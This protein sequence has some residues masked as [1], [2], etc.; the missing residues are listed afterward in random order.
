MTE[1][2]RH[3]EVD[4]PV[5]FPWPPPEDGPILG[6][7]G[8]TWKRASLEPAAFFSRMPRAGGMGAALIYYLAIGMLVA[9]ATFFW[10]SLGGA[11]FQPA[12]FE[13]LGPGAG[14][15]PLVSFLLSPVFL[16]L[17]LALAGGVTHVMLLIVGGATHG[18]AT[19]LRVFCYAYSPQILG[20]IPLAGTVVGTI[21]M[22]VVAIIGLRTAHETDT[23]RPVLAVLLP[24][25]L[26][27]TLVV[28]GLIMVIAAG[29]AL[30][31]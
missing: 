4:A 29:A 28:F 22:L 1:I 30:G 17:G 31:S 23:W 18:F 20:V 26:L 14:D 16:L 13:E 7:F 11:A 3:D 12:A 24:F 25:L 9:G 8:E 6:A 10:Q 27:V 21:W 5:A 19:T 15:N 2:W